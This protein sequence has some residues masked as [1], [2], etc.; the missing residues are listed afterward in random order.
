MY[1][2]QPVSPVGFLQCCRDIYYP[3]LEQNMVLNIKA[4]VQTAIKCIGAYYGFNWFQ[5]L[6]LGKIYS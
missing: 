4:M 2:K 6:D 1:S 3:L 5:S